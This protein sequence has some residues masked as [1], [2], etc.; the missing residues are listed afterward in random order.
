MKRLETL[1]KILPAALAAVFALAALAAP[2]YDLPR[3]VVGAGGGEVAADRFSL[4]GT[5]G[6]SVVAISFHPEI[7]LGVNSGFWHP[8]GAVSGVGGEEND[9]QSVR[10][11]LQ[12]NV[13]NPFNPLTEIRFSIGPEDAIVRLRI[14]DIGGR[15]VRTLHD[16]VYPAGHGKITWNG[17]NNQGGEVPSGM[18]FTSLEIGGQ[19]FTRK[20][21]LVR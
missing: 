9:L 18:Y 19:R 10:P 15:L 2:V 14:F 17:R 16:G 12:T 6:Q 8:T 21:M 4:R 13:P 11:G 7:S 20:M 1:H 3:Q 5:V